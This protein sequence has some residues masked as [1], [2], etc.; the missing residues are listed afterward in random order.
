MVFIAE[1]SFGDRTVSVHLQRMENLPPSELAK[2]RQF[3]WEG[4]KLL[5]LN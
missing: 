4:G 2:M 1:L 3:T 5:Q